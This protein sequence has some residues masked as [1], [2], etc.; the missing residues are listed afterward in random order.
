MAIPTLT[1]TDNVAGIVNRSSSSLIY[2]LTFS[3]PVTGLS[4]DD[5][6]TLN[7]DVVAVTGSGANWQ[8]SVT[9]H[10][11][12]DLAY[13][14]IQLKAG[15]VTNSLGE[16]NAVTTNTAQLIDTLVLPPKLVTDGSYQ[17]VVNPQVTL[18]TGLGAIVIELDPA[19]APVT[20]ANMLA[21][22]NRSFYDGTIFHR[23]INGF[24][25]QGGGLTPA[26]DSK[27]DLYDP[28]VLESK[29]GLSNVRGTV[30]MA[31]TNTPDSATSQF[32][33]NQ[34]DNL[35]LNYSSAASPGYAVFGKVLSGLSV[36]D[37]LAKVPVGT[38]GAY[39]DT[40]LTQEHITSVTQTVA[41][42]AL[43]RTGV[44]GVSTSEQYSTW[45]YSL[46]GGTTW[47]SGTGN[48]LTLPNGSYEAGSVQVRQTD[49][50]GNTTLVPGM[51]TSA[52]VVDP[53]MEGLSGRVYDWKTHT[54]LS[55]VDV[56]L[57]SQSPAASL[58][59]SSGADG[60]FGVVALQ[61]GNYKLEA[62]K[63]LTAA[64]TGSAINSADALAA[65][66]IAVGRNPNADPDGDG[67]LTAP[68]VSPYQF[69]AADAN[70]DGKITSADALAIL[71][72]A[73][74]RSDAPAREWLF[75]NENQDFWNEVTS[76]FMTT[77]SK[78]EWEK[79][80]QVSSPSTAQKNVVAVLKGD[81][82]GSWVAP[83]GSQDLDVM[84]PTYFTDLAAKLEVPAHQWAVMG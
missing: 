52:L 10:L 60:T 56:K 43:S 77:R 28:I 36:V 35:F 57:T 61:A 54:L 80:L 58:A 55:S 1:I 63:A 40:P 2:N 70:Q 62:S 31:R 30:A 48:S 13:M 4:V 7:C 16:V 76:S 21:Y 25:V 26:M 8:V 81:V 84:I 46:N 47:Q 83:A 38:V 12:V 64:E 42:Y 45:S 33:I 82:N 74:K 37:E 19:N 68:P 6:L 59:A 75:V 22:A 41:G 20:V 79:A 51:L 66:K 15:R 71:K 14:G 9:P 17:F 24:M 34:V 69:I 44:L 3:E 53:A 72:M 23:V 65:L 11:N 50:A 39:A 78:V 49:Y 67:P 5:L 18:Q 27:S 32:F 73:V 29:N